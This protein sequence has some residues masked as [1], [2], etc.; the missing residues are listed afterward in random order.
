M[1]WV[2]QLSL[3]QLSVLT[4]YDI[5]KVWIQRSITFLYLSTFRLYFS[6]RQDKLARLYIKTQKQY[7]YEEIYDTLSWFLMNK[8]IINS[9]LDALIPRFQFYIFE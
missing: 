7:L 3:E 1:L 2:Y 5:K 4:K 9:F 6:H 8:L